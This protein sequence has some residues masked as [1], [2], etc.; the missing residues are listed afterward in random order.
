MAEARA[1]AAAAAGLRAQ[2]AAS[3][4]GRGATSGR[5]WAGVGLE[6]TEEAGVADYIFLWSSSRVCVSRPAIGSGTNLT[7]K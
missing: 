7:P 5:G 2:A 4:V 1:R 6:A 3:P